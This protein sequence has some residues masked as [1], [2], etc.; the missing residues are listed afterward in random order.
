SQAPQSFGWRLHGD[1][2]EETFAAIGQR[3]K[4]LTRCTP[5]PWAALVVSEQTRQFY[6][7]KDIAD[8]YLPHLFGA[9]RA[10]CEEHL[11]LTLINDWDVNREAL[12]AYRVVFL[13]NAAA[14]A[15]AQVEALQSYV[16]AGGG[17]V[18][19]AETSLCDELG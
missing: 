10:A 13:P 15:D 8:R 5:M 16:K 11:P 2:T 6:A 17:L 12:A 1:S 7:Y 19:T 14:L 4:W 3:E 9:F 18:A